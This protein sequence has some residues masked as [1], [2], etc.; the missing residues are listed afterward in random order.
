M[1]WLADFEDKTNTDWKVD[2]DAPRSNNQTIKVNVSSNR[3]VVYDN[4]GIFI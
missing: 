2:K 1:K 4:K 3:Y